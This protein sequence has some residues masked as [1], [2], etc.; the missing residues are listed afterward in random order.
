MN[1]FIAIFVYS[2]VRK[3]IERPSSSLVAM[4]LQLDWLSRLV[5]IHLVSGSL[6]KVVSNCVVK[7][8]TSLVS[9]LH[10]L[11]DLWS[12]LC[13]ALPVVKIASVFTK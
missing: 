8:P 4:S 5:L 7:A 3:R 6:T 10:A 11:D 13:V 12:K 1:I 9:I 2:C